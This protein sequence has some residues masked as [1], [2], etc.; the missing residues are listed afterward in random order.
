MVLKFINNASYHAQGRVKVLGLCACFIASCCLAD[1]SQRS[2]AFFY[3]VPLPAPELA[4]FDDVIVEPLNTTARDID[5]LQREG[6]KVFAYLSLGE[7]SDADAKRFSV[8][9]TWTMGRNAAWR[10]AV[11]DQ[12]KPAWRQ[13]LLSERIPALAAAGYDGLFFDTLDSFQLVAD[14]EE[15]RDE[16]IAGL[17]ETIRSIHSQYPMLKLYFN[18]GFELLP[19]LQDLVYALAVE[20]LFE[21]WNAQRKTYQPV[22]AADRRWLLDKLGAVTALHIPVTAI[23]YVA[24]TQPDK[25]F[26]VAKKISALGFTPWV[27]TAALDS[28]GVGDVSLMPR[29]VLVV[30]DSRESALPL[31]PAHVLLGNPLDYLGLRVDY[32][33]INTGVPTLPLQGLYAGLITWLDDAPVSHISQFEHWLVQQLEQKIPLVVIN[34]FPYK[35]RDLLK[36]LGLQPVRGALQKPLTITTQAE[37]V[38][39][40]EAPLKVKRQGVPAISNRSATNTPWLTLQGAN[41]KQLDPVVI[42][43]W[44]GLALFPY[45]K[46]EIRPGFQRWVIEPI[47]FLR[48]A[49]KIENLPVPDSTTETGSRILTSH[50]DGDG[51]VSRAELPNAPYSAEVLLEKIFKPYDLPHT[52]SVI[53]GEVGRKGLYP[54]QS[55]ALEKIARD[56]FRLPNVEIASHSFSHPF[57]WQPQKINS[58]REKQYGVSMPIPNYTVDYRREVIGSIDYINQTLAPPGKRV[59]VMLWTGDALP[60]SEAIALAEAAGVVN[61]NGGDTKVTAAYPSITS[62]YPQLRPTAAGPHIYAPVMNE[63]VYTNEWHGPYYGFRRVIETFKLTDSPRRFK[64]IAIYWHFYSGTKQSSLGALYDIYDWALAQDHTAMYI[65]EYSPKVEGT[66]TTSFARAGSGAILVKGLGPLRTLRIP[67]SLGYPDMRRSEGVAGFIDL[68]QGRYL[69]LSA[70]SAKLFFKK[71]RDKSQPYLRQANAM[72]EYWQANKHGASFRLRGYEPIQLSIEN[73]NHCRIKIGNKWQKAEPQSTLQF[74]KLGIRDTQNALLV[75]Q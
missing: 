7:I 28:M 18:R 52:V 4:Q 11:V 32:H 67:R 20:S 43:P 25:A 39:R 9:G 17:I 19:A 30:Y 42:A 70:P 37:H 34:G 60:S 65:S 22:P 24:A 69:H 31:H 14:N 58:S 63:N 38:G 73:G 66:Y 29:R 6:A 15:K 61:L 46:N 68:P 36:K 5:F 2:A 1:T 57:F 45:V 62:V 75:C 71:Q 50:I 3:A 35:N 27:S 33:D 40:F 8:P 26:E 10:S 49:L 12:R 51:F 55:P 72:V 41:G 47:E 16:Q 21:G 54:E 59:K 44:G 48:S 56:I 23:D 74:F 13:W 64:P 53:E